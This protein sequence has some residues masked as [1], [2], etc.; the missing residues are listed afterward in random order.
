MN[1][2]LKPNLDI[3]F[4]YFRYRIPH[5]FRV[6]NNK[7]SKSS[8]KLT[9]NDNQPGASDVKNS[10]DYKE[11]SLFFKL[12]FKTSLKFK[13]DALIISENLKKTRYSNFNIEEY[14]IYHIMR[15]SWNRFIK[16]NIDFH[17]I[18]CLHEEILI[19]PYAIEIAKIIENNFDKRNQEEILNWV[20][21]KLDIP[22]K[23]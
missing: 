12:T 11:G 7:V 6:I 3:I 15:N 17:L 1:I 19:D 9:N 5:I 16:G 22:V 23:E 2:F 20:E 8:I 4:K 14:Y 13:G 10:S 18:N 21:Y